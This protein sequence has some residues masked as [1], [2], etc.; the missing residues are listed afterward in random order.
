MKSLNRIHSEPHSEDLLKNKGKVL[1]FLGSQGRKNKSVLPSVHGWG[2]TAPSSPRKRHYISASFTQ[3]I[4]EGSDEAG[5]QQAAAALAQAADYN[6]SRSLPSRSSPAL[7]SP[8]P[9]GIKE[10][11][12]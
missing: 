1:I 9:P 4:Q 2:E 12:H 11:V 7:P 6:Q 5:P 8:F 3:V 10:T